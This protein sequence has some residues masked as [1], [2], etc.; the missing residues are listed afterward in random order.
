MNLQICFMNETPSDTE[1]PCS[2]SDVSPGST[3]TALNSKQQQTQQMP[4]RPQVLS[5]PPLRLESC[6]SNSAPIDEADFFARQARLQT[7]AR[8]ALAQA[9]EMAHMQMEVERQRLKQSPITEMV[10]SSLEK[11]CQTGVVE[12]KAE[13]EGAADGEQRSSAGERGAEQAV[14]E[15][16]A[17]APW[18]SLASKEIMPRRETPRRGLVS[19]EN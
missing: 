2:E 8:M 11:R 6:T 19:S 10:R 16:E 13:R 1:S 15:A 14:D 5:L 3:P 12:E 4:V 7:E 18:S 17:H 9:K